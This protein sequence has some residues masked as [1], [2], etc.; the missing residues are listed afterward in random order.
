[1][2]NTIQNPNTCFLNAMFNNPMYNWCIEQQIIYNVV[3]VKQCFRFRF[4]VE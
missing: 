3:K 4:R 1:M 2:Q